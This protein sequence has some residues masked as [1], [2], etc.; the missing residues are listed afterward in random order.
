MRESGYDVSF[1]FGPY[2][3]NT[4]HYAP[5]DLNSLLYKTETDLAWMNRELGHPKEAADWDAKARLRRIRMDQYCWNPSRGLYFDYDFEK[6][7]QSSY[8]FA[9]TFFPLWAG[10]ATPGEAHAVERSFWIV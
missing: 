5:V 7:E 9:T 3:A 2:G 8:E 6:A 1:R 4:Q 10:A